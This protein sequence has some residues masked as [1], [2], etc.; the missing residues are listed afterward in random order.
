MLRFRRMKS[1]Q[2][3]ASVHAS[4]R[5]HFDSEHHLVD[6][7]TYKLRR[8]RRVAEPGSLG[9]CAEQGKARRTESGPHPSGSTPEP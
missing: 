1:L 7:Q 5:N 8:P 2:K 9:H 3:F 4:F 6:R